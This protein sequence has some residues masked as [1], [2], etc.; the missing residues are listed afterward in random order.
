ML[1]EMKSM[2]L[3]AWVL[4]PTAFLVSTCSLSSRNLSFLTYK[5]KMMIMLPHVV[6]TGEAPMRIIV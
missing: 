5:M 6:V 2:E 1:S 3:G 4:C